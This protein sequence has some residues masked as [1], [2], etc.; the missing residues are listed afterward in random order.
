MKG[1]GESWGVFGNRDKDS[2]RGRGLGL[3]IEDMER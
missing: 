1:E 3:T 2:G